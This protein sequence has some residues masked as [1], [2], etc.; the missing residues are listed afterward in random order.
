MSENMRYLTPL[1]E[2]AMR[3]EICPHCRA[4][5]TLDDFYADVVKL[6]RCNSCGAVIVLKVTPE[7]RKSSPQQA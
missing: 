2:E 6:K 4:K 7:L 5:G 1:H 3:L